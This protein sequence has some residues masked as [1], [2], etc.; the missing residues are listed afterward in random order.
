MDNM[1]YVTTYIQIKVKSLCGD[2]E[3]ATISVLK[4]L[5]GKNL[6]VTNRRGYF[7][8]QHYINAVSLN[9]ANNETL[10]TVGEAFGRFQGLISDF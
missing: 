7:R 10:C 6:V 8:L 4:T 3:K 9:S 2:P 5:K 1:V